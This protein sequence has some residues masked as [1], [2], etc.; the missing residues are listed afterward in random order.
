MIKHT[1]ALWLKAC[2]DGW[3]TKC[4]PTDIKHVRQSLDNQLVGIQFRTTATTKS[5]QF[6][7]TNRLS[8]GAL[9]NHRNNCCHHLYNNADV[10]LA[11]ESSTTDPTWKTSIICISNV[12]KNFCCF[13]LIAIDLCKSIII[14]Y[15]GITNCNRRGC[16]AYLYWGSF[17]NE[18]TFC[19]V[20]AQN[21]SKYPALS[22]SSFN[23]SGIVWN[24]TL[25]YDPRIAMIQ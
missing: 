25:T 8:F 16:V 11:G 5:W 1:R 6:P 18:N 17:L 9:L 20:V 14:T 4:P 23:K 22:G 2:M 12:N 24:S 13:W 15:S 19:V 10:A 7:N 3:T 21:I